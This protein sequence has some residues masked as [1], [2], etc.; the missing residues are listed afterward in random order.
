M[1][2]DDRIAKLS[3]RFQNHAVGRKPSAPR[4]RERRS[5]YLDS[6]LTERL[7]RQYKELEHELY[8]TSLSKS[9]FLEALFEYSLDHLDEIR[10]ELAQEP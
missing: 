8:P 4:T 7:D 10:A 5:F 6:D 2:K 1:S 9:E 3:S